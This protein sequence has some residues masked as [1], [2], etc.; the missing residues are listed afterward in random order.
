[1]TNNREL[2]EWLGLTYADLLVYLAF[3]SVAL[4]LFVGHA[5]LDI[6]LAIAAFTLA[7]FS[8]PIG[9]KRNPKLS[10]FTNTAKRIS[11]PALTV[12]VALTIAFHYM[13]LPVFGSYQG[14]PKAYYIPSGSMYPT[15]QINDRIFVDQGLYESQTPQRGEIVVFQPTEALASNGFTGVV[16]ARIVGL[17]NEE[18]EIRD[19]MT[20]IDQQPIEEPY[21]AEPASYQFGPV[22]VPENAYFVL[23][24]NR[25]NAYDSQDWGFVPHTNLAG[26]VNLIYWPPNR[27]GSPYQE[28]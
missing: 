23:G 7:L 21:T 28:D 8:C 26:K 24:D 6:F 9:M 5:G 20:L 19:G 13:I 25:N 27:Y 12:I 22:V 2:A 4:M 17:P 16:V 15:L 18:I 11:Y 14:S 10:N 3:G 1:M